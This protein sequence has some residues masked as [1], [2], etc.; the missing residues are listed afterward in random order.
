MLCK[1]QLKF[2]I[3]FFNFI[4]SDNNK[5]SIIFYNLFLQLFRNEINCIILLNV[6]KK[7]LNFK[8]KLLLHIFIILLLYYFCYDHYIYLREANF[9]INNSKWQM[10][11][12]SGIS[13]DSGYLKI[14][15]VQ[16]RRI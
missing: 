1:I 6:L 4:Y 14:F 12:P 11:P 13:L 7:K 2:K 15:L 8:L 9:L 10:A 3:V 16:L 5:F